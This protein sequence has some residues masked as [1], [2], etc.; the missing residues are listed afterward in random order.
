MT[1]IQS[2][3]AARLATGRRTAKRLSRQAGCG[4]QGVDELRREDRRISRRV[5]I[6]R[7]ACT[8]TSYNG[9]KISPP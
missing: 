2:Y 1:D 4:H 9:T 3:E 8:A 7:P 6:A 5:V